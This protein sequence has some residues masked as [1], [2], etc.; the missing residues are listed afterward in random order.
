MTGVGV[1]EPMGRDM[2]INSCS[3]SRRLD[4]PMK[5]VAV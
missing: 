5:L 3:F 4:N 1:S 2:G